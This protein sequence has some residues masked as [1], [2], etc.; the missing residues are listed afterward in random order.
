MRRSSAGRFAGIGCN[1]Q[2]QVI[3]IGC[4]SARLAMSAQGQKHA[5]DPM[6]A[7]V[8]ASVDARLCPRGMLEIA[9]AQPAQRRRNMVGAIL[10][11]PQSH[12]ER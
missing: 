9:A 2:P 6:Q 8:R 10:L 7:K 12:R 1:L 4:R 11:F 3:L 5:H